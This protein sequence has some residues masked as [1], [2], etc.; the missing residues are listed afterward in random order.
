MPHQFYNHVQPNSNTAQQILFTVMLQK[1]TQRPVAGFFSFSSCFTRM[2]AMRDTLFF[3][4]L[5]LYMT[6]YSLY[7]NVIYLPLS[8]TLT[9]IKLQLHTQSLASIFVLI[10]LHNFG[11]LIATVWKE[12][13]GL[14]MGLPDSL[15]QPGFVPECLIR[16]V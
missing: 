16:Y 7:N 12:K 14:A 13:L 11:E 1:I 6:V 4:P 3:I 8:A 15:C 10:S 5:A 9:A 2:V